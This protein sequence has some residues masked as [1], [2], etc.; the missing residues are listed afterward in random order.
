MNVS[1]DIRELVERR[2]PG[3][4]LDAPFY[5]SEAIFALD[6]D[7]I[8]RKHWI[9]VAVEPDVPEPG[10]YVTVEIAGESVLIVRDDDMSVRAF[11][12]VCRHRGARLCNEDKGT[13]G[14]I[15]CPYHSWTYNLGGEL[16]FAEHMGEKFDRCKHS[17]KPVHL[18][19]LAGLIFICLA[20]EPPADFPKMR[21]AMEP[22]LLPHDLPNCK[23]AA[24]VDLIEEGNWKLTMENN[25]E[26]YHCVANHPELTISLYEYGFGYQPSPSNAEG[27]AAFER[28]C[29][30]RAAEWEAMRLPSVEIERLL[31]TTGFRT[32]RL[33]L[34]RSGESQTLDAKVASKKLLGEFTRADLGGLSFWTQP[35]SWNHFM[36]DHIVTF[37]VIPLSAGKTLVR[38]KWL[39]HKDAVEG[40]DYDVKNLTA[41]WN[42]TNDQDRRLVE[43]SQRGAASSA[44]EP[45][46]YSP[47]T[48]GLVEKFCDWYVT[49]L[50]EH[51]GV[52]NR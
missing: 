25:R 44:Y 47:Y 5:L 1:A 29:V 39:V 43:F 51:L 11:H 21:S 2:K 14:N 38:T 37:S 52:A 33:P 16:M 12:N 15:V 10:D 36:S 40:V 22:Y 42:A 26:C 50:A 30:E 19:N 31:D 3:Y 34:D 24:Q 49:R 46:P 48:E 9:Q 4:S 23:I 13:V 7:A 35:N 18:H 41:V 32:Q 17:L 45:G 6:I 27:M 28:A 20:E 8:F